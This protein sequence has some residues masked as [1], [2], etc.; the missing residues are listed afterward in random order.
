MSGRPRKPT[1]LIRAQGGYARD[2]AGEPLIPPGGL[3]PPE[4]LSEVATEVWV[5]AVK[6]LS[7]VEGLLT[8][9]DRNIL[10]RYANCMARY[11]DGQAILEKEGVLIDGA[12]NARVKH[13]VIQVVR[14]A[15]N[16][17]LQLEKQMG[18]TPSARAGLHMS[19]DPHADMNTMLG[20]A[21]DSD[22]SDD[23]MLQE[24]SAG[25]L[26]LVAAGD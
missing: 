1:G 23:A 7:S 14:D 26:R 4:H 9:A 3:G 25:G 8:R 24:V 18:L 11:H 22:D 20:D 19:K 16:E 6:A 2:R 15:S 13:P 21:D 5:E 12:K 17:A 10:L